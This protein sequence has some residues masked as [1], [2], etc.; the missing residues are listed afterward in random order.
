MTTTTISIKSIGFQAWQSDAGH[1]VRAGRN[2]NG[3]HYISVRGSDG[4]LLEFY[5]DRQPWGIDYMPSTH[6]IRAAIRRYDS[7]E[8]GSQPNDD[9]RRQTE[10]WEAA[11]PRIPM[12]QG[13]LEALI[14]ADR[15]S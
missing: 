3:R 1:M 11:H 4:G 13:G 10:A 8:R 14:A 9:A 7:G 2:G 12:N 5:R 15:P 6:E